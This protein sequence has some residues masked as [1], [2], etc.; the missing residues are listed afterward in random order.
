MTLENDTIAGATL[1][2]LEVRLRRL[3][4]LLTGDANWTGHPKA[5]P[6]PDTLD[7]TVARRLARLEAGLEK[8]SKEVPAVHDVLQLHDRF[9]ELFR[10]PSP[11]QIPA[12]LTVQNLAS[13]VLS[14]A[15]AFPETA[16]RLTS[17][18]DLP[19]PDAKLSTGLIELQPRLDRLAEVQEEQAKEVSELRTRSAKVLQRWYEVGLLG[20]GECWA[21]WEA[22]LEDVDREVKREEVAREKRAKML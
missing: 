9:P 21:E 14:Y 22:R 5:A 11:N 7:D 19:V 4:Y 13:I 3:E 18:N 6:K 16:S 15:S 20:S 10:S 1:E 12:G 2:L 8:L 17:L